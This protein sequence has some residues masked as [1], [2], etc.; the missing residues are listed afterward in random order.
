MSQAPELEVLIRP[1]GDRRHHTR[2]PRISPRTHATL[3]LLGQTTRFQTPFHPESLDKNA[4]NT[5]LS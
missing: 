4:A 5:S 2:A 1:S 3:S